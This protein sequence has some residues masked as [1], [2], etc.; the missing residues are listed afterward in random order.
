MIQTFEK[1]EAISPHTITN[2]GC[3]A[4][5]SNCNDYPVI[6]QIVRIEARDNRGNVIF[7]IEGKDIRISVEREELDYHY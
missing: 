2:T 5:I 4:V 1:N 6:N 7:S 3:R